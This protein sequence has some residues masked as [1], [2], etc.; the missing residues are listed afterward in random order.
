MDNTIITS[1]AEQIEPIIN[2]DNKI[3]YRDITKLLSKPRLFSHIIN[4]MKTII[5][6]LHCPIDY[7]AGFD[8]AGFGYLYTQLSH[9]LDK[10]FVILKKNRNYTDRPNYTTI[11]YGND[12]LS[13][14]NDIIP[15]NSNVLFISNLIATGNTFWTAYELIKQIGSNPIGCISLIQLVGLEVNAKFTENNIPIFS[16]IKYQHDSISKIIDP[17]INPDLFIIPNE[18][19]PMELDIELNDIIDETIVFYHTSLKT[20]GENYI[21][22]NANC[23]KGS[24]LWNT[25]ADKQPNITFEHM[26]QLKNKRV[27]FFISLFDKSNLF[28]QISLLMVLPRQLIKSLNIYIPYFAVGTMERADHEGIVATAETM[29]KTISKC[30]HSTQQGP[31]IVHIWDIHATPTK[32]YF[33]DNIIVK[34]ETGIPLLSQ[35]ITDK[36]IIVFPDDGARKRFGDDFKKYKKIVCSKVREGNNRFIRIVDKINFPI[37]R[38]ILDSEYDMVII[39]DDL[40]QSGST[41]DECRKELKR[42]GYKNI[43]AYV[44]HS[45]FPLGWDKFTNGES[46]FKFFTT[47]TV[48]EV[49]DK[50]KHIE[51][52]QVFNIF[53]N[54]EYKPII[55]YVS[56]HDQHKLKSVYNAISNILKNNNI[57]VIGL[58]IY[59]NNTHEQLIETEISLT[60]SERLYNM[61]NYLNSKNINYDYCFSLENGLITANN[62]IYDIC[63]GKMYNKN[64]GT[65]IEYSSDND[66]K[67]PIEYYKSCIDNSS[68][69]PISIGKI[70]SNN[71]GIPEDL[72]YEFYN[73]KKLN[74]VQ[75]MTDVI[76]K[77]FT[78]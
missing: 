26:D 44:T 32:F 11:N 66:V 20:L 34:L 61:I 12:Q 16:V 41:L 29:A 6:N 30:V 10:G 56:S 17:L 71:T 64:N 45:I 76:K 35:V 55:I 1:M 14:I 48:P 51:P 22:N 31:P 77:C 75:I 46:F 78:N 58:N 65:I 70:I 60:C 18:Y 52:F 63:I 24:I 2:P 28:E 38:E 33:T 39:I 9:D 43:C 7:I 62:L 8:E 23:R 19:I 53:G 69:I 57:T 67:I 68:G 73:D 40:V 13:I 42:V 27:V 36:T 15:P 21:A 49:T 74:K 4:Y 37:N 72:Y 50:L 47:N 3:V 59:S 25:F 54:Q 5:E